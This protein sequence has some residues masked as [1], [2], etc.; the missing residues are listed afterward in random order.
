MIS[1]G[2]QGETTVRATDTKNA[3]HYDTAQVAVLPAAKTAFLPSRVE[4]EVGSALV[5][6]L[7]AY[8]KRGV[9]RISKHLTV[10]S[11]QRR[12]FLVNCR[13]TVGGNA[14]LSHATV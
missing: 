14:S 3:A 8:A 9:T 12:F 10:T 2:G 4:A 5:L 1:S 11:F 7:A 13:R 6:P